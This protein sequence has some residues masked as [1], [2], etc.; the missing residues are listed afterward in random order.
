VIDRFAFE[1]ISAP[2]SDGE[3]LGNGGFRSSLALDALQPFAQGFR[4]RV[5]HA[6]AGL[7]GKRLSELMGLGIFDVQGHLNL[8]GRRFSTFLYY[9][10]S[11]PPLPLIGCAPQKLD[12]ARPELVTRL[13][14][15]GGIIAA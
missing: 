12:S 4:H 15:G 9:S 6:F 13:L 7:L 14:A 8:L 2:A 10:P 5:R 1:R 3:E 11:V